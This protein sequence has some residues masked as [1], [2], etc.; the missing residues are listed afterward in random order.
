ML[1]VSFKI[2]ISPTPVAQTRRNDPVG[3]REAVKCGPWRPAAPATKRCNTDK[4]DGPRAI[5]GI[6]SSQTRPRRPCAAKQATRNPAAWPYGAKQ[7]TQPSRPGHTPRNRPRN[8]AAWPHP[9]SLAVHPGGQP[10]EPSIRPSYWSERR[11]AAA[12]SGAGTPSSPAGT[13][14]VSVA[15]P[16]AALAPAAAPAPAPA[17]SAAA[18]AAAASS[19]PVARAPAAPA[20]AALVPT[21]PAA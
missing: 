12:A 16:A 21:S 9:R 6:W 15:P 4:P 2:H 14:L 8:P 11:P 13:A 3:R 10:S 19:A 20:L 1:Y 17:W 5:A 18:P 7:A